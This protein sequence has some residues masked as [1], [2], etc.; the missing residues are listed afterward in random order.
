MLKVFKKHNYLFIH[1]EKFKLFQNRFPWC[2]NVL[3]I[4]VIIKKPLF[5]TQTK[6]SLNS[7]YRLCLTRV[8]PS[9]SSRLSTQRIRRTCSRTRG[10]SISSKSLLRVPRIP[11]PNLA[12]ATY[13]RSK[14]SQRKMV[15]V[16]ATRFSSFT[17][18]TIRPTW[19]R[20]VCLEKVLIFDF[21]EFLWIQGFQSIFELESCLLS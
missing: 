9:A 6:D 19:W 13:K 5:K 4:F 12:P 15:C 20:C 14:W 1:S 2:K 8:R 7:S 16:C 10:A 11:I 18:A 3:K 17:R 21:Y